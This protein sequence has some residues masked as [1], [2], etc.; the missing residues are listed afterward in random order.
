M[1]QN[2]C[3]LASIAQTIKH[4]LCP[5]SPTSQRAQVVWSPGWQFCMTHQRPVLELQVVTTADLAGLQAELL[6]NHFD[7]LQAGRVQH[8]ATG[9]EG[10]V[11]IWVHWG[12]DGLWGAGGVEG[13]TAQTWTK[14]EQTKFRSRPSQCNTYSP[15]NL[16]DALCIL[17]WRQ[18]SWHLQPFTWQRQSTGLR[19]YCPQWCRWH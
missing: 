19:S 15:Q 13:T 12:G 14:K 10:W 1:T 11:G 18:R 8:P 4:H 6:H 2:Q 5:L 17:Y 3:H 16:L 7:G 9:G